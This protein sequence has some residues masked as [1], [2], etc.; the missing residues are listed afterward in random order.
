MYIFIFVIKMPSQVV[1][2]TNADWH[3]SYE[4]LAKNSIVKADV[5]KKGLLWFQFIGSHT[6][7]ILAPTGKLQVKW[8]DLNEKIL[9]FKWIKNI[10]IANSNE[11]LCIKP[12]KQQTWIEYP[13]PGSFKLYWCDQATEFVLKKSCSEEKISK[14]ATNLTK[15]KKILEELRHELCHYREPTLNEVALQTGY[16]SPQLRDYLTL[17]DWKNESKKESK[18][19]AE[20]A[21]N[22][23]GWL[24]YRKTGDLSPMLISLSQKAID[25]A[26]MFALKKAQIIIANYPELVPKVDLKGLKWPEETKV[27]W[28]RIFG[29]DPPISQFLN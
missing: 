16:L 8:S 28:V 29:D 15:V 26:S 1:Y 6:V 21:I 24:N 27:K 23:A 3:E 19:V 13:V 11:K 9:L 14:V 17:A 7:F 4:A 10:L 20:Q 2:Q 5:T 18:R 12:L 22:L 25:S